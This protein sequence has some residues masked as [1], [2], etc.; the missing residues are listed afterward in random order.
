MTALRD[1]ASAIIRSLRDPL[2][3]LDANLRV[4]TANDAFYRT[5]QVSPGDSE[6]RLVYELGN[7]Q[8]DIPQ[9]R[10]L[11]EEVLPRTTAFDDFEVTHTFESLGQRTMLLNA[12]RL[13]DADGRPARILLSIQDVTRSF[14]VQATARASQARYQAL[15]EASAQIVWTTDQTGAV[16]ED[17]PS[18]RAFTGQTFEEW[19]GFGWLD[20]IHPD[21]RGRV[22][23]LWRCAVAEVTP[24]NTDYRVRH[25]GGDWRW[26]DVRAV[27]VLNE[28]GSVREWVGMNVDVSERREA[29]QKL[30]HSEQRFTR[31]MHHLPGLAWIK[32]SEGR[33]VYVNDA[34]E[35]AFHKGRDIL[36]GKN[37]GDLFPPETAAQFTTNDQCV[38]EGESSIQTI[39]SLKHDDGIVH[40]SIVNKFAIPGSGR[41]AA[42]VAGVAIDI[43]E[44]KRAEEALRQS[45]ERYR[46]LF[47]TID[48]GFCIIERVDT[49]PGEPLDFR[50]IEANPAFAVQAGVAGVVGK[51]IRQ[52]FP[53]EPD[54]GTEFIVRLPILVEAPP[55]P[56]EDATIAR[57]LTALRILVV[58]DNRDAAESLALLLG[59]HGHETHTAHDGLA[60]VKAASQ[61]D[62]DVILMDIGLPRL[63]GYEAARRIRE[64][65]NRGR[66]LVLVA[67]TGWG[68]EEDRRRSRAA[69]FDAHVVKPVDEAVLRRL[70]A[71]LTGVAVPDDVSTNRTEAG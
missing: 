22:S 59:F 29:E 17:S 68:Q 35:R 36:Y 3:I 66:R 14:D 34:A 15:V 6:G 7:H 20:A 54:L 2:L 25:V 37:D 55:V 46:T 58:D 30:R 38:L 65:Q 69:G 63:N 8:W 32:D 56:A 40:H 43:T 1:D 13:D 11:L 44:L 26:V 23:Q 18:W 61:L 51:T 70:L 4:E 67:L 27:P 39:E 33:Y 60:A 64:Q 45:E 16:V 24:V 10:H 71:D 21:D 28:D 47:A 5:F 49:R 57:T 12:R 19:R 50:Y 52:A 53:G 48:E 42:M 9:L 41:E 31:F 62:P